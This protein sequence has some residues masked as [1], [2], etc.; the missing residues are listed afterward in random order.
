[1][2][3]ATA[4][5][6]GHPGDESGDRFLAIVLN[7]RRRFFFSGSA[8]FADQD[9]RFCL[10]IFIEEFHRVEMR[11]TADRIAADANAGR[12]AMTARSQLPNRLVR[13]R[14]RARDHADAARLV[15]VTRHDPNLACAGSDDTRAIRAD[16]S[17]FAAVHLRLHTHHVHHRNSFRDTNHQLH[18]GIDCFEN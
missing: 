11:Q 8:D 16:E 17:R 12:L 13:E 7:P 5:R 1:M 9:H 2:T 15:N 3:H 18:A 10:S 4:R 6:R 14:A